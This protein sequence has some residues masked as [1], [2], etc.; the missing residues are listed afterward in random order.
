MWTKMNGRTLM[1]SKKTKFS[2]EETQSNLCS[3]VITLIKIAQAAS[4]MDLLLITMV[5]QSLVPIRIRE[6][7][8]KIA[9]ARIW[10]MKK[11]LIYH[12]KMLTS[13]WI[14]IDWVKLLKIH[15]NVLEND[16]DIRFLYSL[17]YWLLTIRDFSL[18]INKIINYFNNYI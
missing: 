8:Y 4:Q 5:L 6:V 12:K 14:S 1:Q 16:K 3:K 18:I 7:T 17:E 15:C 10:L 13:M 2:W 11:I 9:Q